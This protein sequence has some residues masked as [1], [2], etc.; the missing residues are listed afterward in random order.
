MSAQ[1]AYELGMLSACRLACAFVSCLER[2]LPLRGFPHVL[3]RWERWRVRLADGAGRRQ[4]T[5]R[6]VADLVAGGARVRVEELGVPELADGQQPCAG[7]VAGHR[8]RV[9]VG[10]D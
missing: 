9:M 5:G 4:S 2:E 7:Q 1:R 10:G 6:Q 3:G 8:D